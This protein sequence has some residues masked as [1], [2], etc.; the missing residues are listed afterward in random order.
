VNSIPF[1]TGLDRERNHHVA[2]ASVP[3]LLKEELA[4]GGR[5]EM[6]DYSSIETSAMHFPKVANEEAQKGWTV[7]TVVPASYLPHT[8]ASGLKLENIVIY[9]ERDQ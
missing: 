9:F 4:Q 1:G 6:K 5:I 7:L 3:A 8:G 2:R